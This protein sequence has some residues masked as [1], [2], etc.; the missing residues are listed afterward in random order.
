M[1]AVVQQSSQIRILHV[2]SLS[3]ERYWNLRESLKECFK[4]YY[5]VKGLPYEEMRFDMKYKIDLD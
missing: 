1:E 4:D 3:P 2:E 5:E